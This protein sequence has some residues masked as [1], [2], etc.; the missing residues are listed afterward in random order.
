MK[1]LLYGHF[2]ACNITELWSLSAAG[3]TFFSDVSLLD[4]D[5]RYPSCDNGS[6][7]SVVLVNTTLNTATV[8]YYT[9][10]TPGSRVCFVCDEGSGYE[11][12]TTTSERLCKGSGLWS[13]DSIVCSTL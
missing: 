12:N 9:G 11:L 1:L 7:G 8:A 2:T 3:V 13:G 10:T 5:T 6:V 4:E